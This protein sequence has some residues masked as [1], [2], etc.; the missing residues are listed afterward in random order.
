MARLIALAVI[1]LASFAGHIIW[2]DT[3]IWGS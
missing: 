2:G 3:V 1:V